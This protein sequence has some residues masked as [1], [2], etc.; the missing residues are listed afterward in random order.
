MVSPGKIC[1]TR[2]HWFFTTYKQ[3]QT[4]SLL[5]DEKQKQQQHQSEQ[6]LRHSLT[7]NHCRVLC[8]N[9]SSRYN[10]HHFH[11]AMYSKPSTQNFHTHRAPS[12]YDN[13]FFMQKLG[14]LDVIVSVGPIF[15]QPVPVHTPKAI[16]SFPKPCP[17]WFQCC[18]NWWKCGF[19]SF[20]NTNAWK[21][22]IWLVEGW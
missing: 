1:I 21:K 18:H 7:S 14:L 11:D 12:L 10:F 15:W 5:K 22:H 9:E 3:F 2:L 8:T 20:N 19:D 16:N 13:E 4:W 6:N 17:R